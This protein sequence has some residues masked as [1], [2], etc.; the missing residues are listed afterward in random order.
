MIFLDKHPFR[1]LTG[2]L[3]PC[4]STQR[5]IYRLL[6]GNLPSAIRYNAFYCST[7]LVF[8]DS[9]ANISLPS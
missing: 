4:C 5:A 1:Q 9:Y 3:C 2:L 6:N 8:R 7:S